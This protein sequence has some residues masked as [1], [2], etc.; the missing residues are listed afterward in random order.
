MEVCA[1]D[2]KGRELYVKVGARIRELRI[3]K[4]MSQADLSEKAHVSL[5]H[6]SAIELGKTQMLLG[7]FL[8]IAE[9]LQIS[10]DALLRPDIPEVNI[11]YQTE[12]AE[13]FSDCTP[14]ELDAILKIVKELKTTLHMN[15]ID[16]DV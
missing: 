6:I 1:M 13:L 11:I 4:K 15:R 7:T 2:D 9:A 8:N 16:D 14:T 10:S 3:Q 5:P 12:F